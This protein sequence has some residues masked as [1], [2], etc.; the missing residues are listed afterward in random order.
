MWTFSGSNCTQ[1]RCQDAFSVLCVPFPF[2]P[3]PAN[4]VTTIQLTEISLQLCGP[5]CNITTSCSYWSTNRRSHEARRATGMRY[6]RRAWPPSLS[7]RSPPIGRYTWTPKFPSD[8][9]GSPGAKTCRYPFVRWPGVCPSQ[10][11]FTKLD[12][13]QK[14]KFDAPCRLAA[15]PVRGLRGESV[16]KARG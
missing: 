16:K 8:T 5:F 12:C 9:L 7:I 15:V 4:I 11:I 10:I 2:P 1:I 13:A 3:S 6:A 14:P